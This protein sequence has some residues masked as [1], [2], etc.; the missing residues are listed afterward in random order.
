MNEIRYR[1]NW[2]VDFLAEDRYRIYRHSLIWIY[3]IFTEL[4]DPVDPKGFS[5]SYEFY[6]RITKIVFFILMVYINM[7]ILVPK[8]LFNDRYFA[9]ILA[10]IIMIVFIHL[11]IKGFFEYNFKNYEILDRQRPLGLF[12]EI[13][14]NTNLFGV[15]V[16][17]STSIKLFQRWKKD[18]TRMS[19]LEKNS[20]ETELREL[21]N[22]INPH[23]LFNMLNNV[24]VLVRRDPDK[25]SVVLLRLSDFLRYQLYE[26]TGHSVSLQSEITFLKDF[27]ELEK[28]RRDDFDFK[29]L[30]EMQ[31]ATIDVLLPPNLFIIFVENGVK[32]STDPDA[33]SEVKLSFEKNGERLL[34]TCINTKPV[35]P[36]L[37]TS[38]SGLGLA[39]IYR[40]LDL[41]YGSRYTLDI[42]EDLSLYKVILTIP[43]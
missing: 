38:D 11:L 28:I 16:L 37:T 43:L 23:F 26:T 39:N 7:Y 34:F 29:I 42:E 35:E 36:L 30:N 12:R 9:Y 22:Q 24:N 32:H 8:L 6:L 14:S 20:L 15:I 19:E 5:G 18:S 27:M 21:K 1:Q 13:V 33:P 25:A 10:L 4:Q 3:L 40:R 31:L 41:L 17:S 2:F